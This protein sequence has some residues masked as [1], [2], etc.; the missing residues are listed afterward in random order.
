MVMVLG[1]VQK[2]RL[3]MMIWSRERN[4]EQQLSEGKNG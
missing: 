4:Q 3:A 2:A 1:V